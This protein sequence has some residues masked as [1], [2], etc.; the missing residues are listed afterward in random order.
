MKPLRG[1]RVDP[2]SRPGKFSS[3]GQPAGGGSPIR[4]DGAVVGL[5]PACALFPGRAP[6][7][8]SRRSEA[9]WEGDLRPVAEELRPRSCG[10]VGRPRVF[11]GV[12]AP[13]PPR[14]F[15]WGGLL[16]AVLTDRVCGF[17]RGVLGVASGQWRIGRSSTRPVLKHGPRS[18]TCAR[19]MGCYET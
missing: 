3:S 14:A 13:V 11:R 4:K 15:D 17:E 18:L 1:K 2:Q 9:S 19:V 10:L 8:V 16:T 5:V 7:P 12:L 6:R